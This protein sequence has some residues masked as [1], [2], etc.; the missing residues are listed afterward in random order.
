MLERMYAPTLAHFP[1]QDLAWY[2]NVLSAVVILPLCVIGGEVP[3]L[4]L[5]LADSSKLKS[6]LI[7]GLVTV[8]P[9]HTPLSLCDHA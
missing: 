2:S 5:M 7:G 8:R 3:A 9:Q 6:F 4:G 1:L